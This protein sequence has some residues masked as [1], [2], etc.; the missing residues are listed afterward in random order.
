MGERKKQD[1]IKISGTTYKVTRTFSGECSLEDI[2]TDW[3]MEK[4]LDAIDEEDTSENES[5]AETENAVMSI[6]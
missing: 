3:A 6:S 5:E 4:T 2:I 1:E